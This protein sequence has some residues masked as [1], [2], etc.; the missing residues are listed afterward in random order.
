MNRVAQTAASL[1]AE[2][3]TRASR[4][5]D[6][7]A[8]LRAAIPILRADE[9]QRFA[10]ETSPDGSA[11]TPLA[12]TTARRKG[13]ADI[14]VDTGSLEAAATSDAAGHIERIEANTLIYGV[15][16]TTDQGGIP[17][18]GLQQA[19]GGK[20]PARPFLGISDEAIAK[21]VVAAGDAELKS[22]E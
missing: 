8:A 3:E 21:L 4:G 2:L 6:F 9:Q 13:N 18:A 10:S 5:P 19:G 12:P 7:S 17:W 22:W 15:D 20:L 16:G 14:L 11:W 1:A